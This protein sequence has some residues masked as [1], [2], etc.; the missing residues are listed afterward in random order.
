MQFKSVIT[1]PH[2]HLPKHVTFIS[3]IGKLNFREVTQLVTEPGIE[4]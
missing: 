2:R 4:F 3:E 1:D